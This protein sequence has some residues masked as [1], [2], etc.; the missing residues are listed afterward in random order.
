M[1]KS[2]TLIL[3]FTC[4]FTNIVWAQVNYVLNPS[5][6]AYRKCPS[7]YDQI[8]FANYWSGIDTNWIPDSG[9]PAY[10]Y[11]LPDYCNS[12]SDNVRCR[13]PNNLTFNQFPRTGNGM[14]QVCMFFNE[15][16]S[17]PENRDYLQGRLRHNLTEGI[18]YCISFF[19]NFEGM[20]GTM[21]LSGY[22]IDHIGAYLDNGAID[23]DTGLSC[24]LPKPSLMPQVYTTS[25][26]T[27]TVNWT[28]IQGNFIATGTE[29]FIT[30]GNFFDKSHTNFVLHTT[31]TLDYPFSAYLIDDVSVIASDEVAHAG[32]DV[33]IGRGDS[34]HIGTFEEG[35][36]CTWY[37]AGSSVPIGY[38]GGLW[39][40]P[41]TNTIYVVELDLCGNVTRDSVQVTVWPTGIKPLADALAAITITPN[42]AHCAIK[43]AGAKD[44]NVVITDMVGR[45][46][47][48]TTATTAHEAIDISGIAPGLYMAQVVMP[49]GGRKLIRLAI[50]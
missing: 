21:P 32:A 34:V 26:I 3:F 45:E 41:D 46:V 16:V 27:D 38:S 11:C 12:C 35:M 36:P 50:Q 29:K 5:F 24:T 8:S 14:A 33:G 42:P 40:R 23:I 2:I 37:V 7:R 30:I 25:I 18:L 20:E 1:S 47:L 22:A 9:V 49:N 6:E 31:D 15:Y 19:V 48:H 28:K 13:V 39:V 43:L 10:L 4:A 44:C 17:V